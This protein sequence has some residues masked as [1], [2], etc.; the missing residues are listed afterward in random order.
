MNI[1]LI[2]NEENQD[3]AQRGKNQ[4]GGMIAFVCRAGKHVGNSTPKD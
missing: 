1:Q 3:R 2:A 4:T